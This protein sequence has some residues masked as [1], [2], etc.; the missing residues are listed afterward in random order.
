MKKQEIFPNLDAKGAFM[1][2]VTVVQHGSKAHRRFRKCTKD[3]ASSD[4]H[5]DL[6]C[7]NT[8]GSMTCTFE[9]RSSKKLNADHECI[10]TAK[11]QTLDLFIR[12]Q[13]RQFGDTSIMESFSRFIAKSGI[14]FSAAT[15]KEFYHFVHLLLA[16]SA[17]Q[18]PLTPE[19]IFPKLTNKQLRNEI[20]RYAQSSYDNF[21]QTI[22]GTS[23]ALTIDATTVYSSHFIVVCCQS[24]LNSIPPHLIR[25]HETT[26]GLD[27]G[28]Y[29][30]L[31]K[32]II[33]VLLENDISII[34]FTTDGFLAQVNA[35]TY[36]HP[37][38]IAR[39]NGGHPKYKSIIHNRCIC[40]R[41]WFQ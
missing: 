30:A 7:L 2:N 19:M 24:L 11:N 18:Q 37:E 14:S 17:S 23:V 20:H 27:T 16:R 10:F 34:S 5:Y 38:S 36:D 31:C 15:S 9:V 41:Y 3:G 40:H 39:M 6:H 25:L 8:S 35:L 32:D 4:S 29:A 1:T 12:K 21:V 26:G 13:N 22:K 28:G 33:D